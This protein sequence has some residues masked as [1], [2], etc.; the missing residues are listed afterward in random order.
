MRAVIGF[1]LRTGAHWLL[2]FAATV[3]EAA[4]SAG[5]AHN[6]RIDAIG[7]TLVY[8]VSLL[9]ALGA[10]A[11]FENSCEIV[12]HDYIR[13]S[14]TNLRKAGAA[15]FFQGLS[16]R[17]F[18]GILDSLSELR[19][20]FPRRFRRTRLALSLP[21]RSC[22][23]AW[24]FRKQAGTLER[25]LCRLVRRQDTIEPLACLRRKG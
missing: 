20:Y 18:L 16:P 12:T 9:V 25:P 22:R 21:S 23:L 10:F 24:K 1:I 14:V 17:I 4:D 15:L 6:A 11:T 5:N 8:V 3:T 7:I 19:E 13:V 2:A